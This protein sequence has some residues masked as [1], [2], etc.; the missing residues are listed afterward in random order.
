[1]ATKYS[2]QPLTKAKAIGKLKRFLQGFNFFIILQKYLLIF[3]KKI[4]H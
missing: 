4:L 3:D 1:M 2:E